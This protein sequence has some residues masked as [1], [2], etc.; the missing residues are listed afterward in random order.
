MPD[1]GVGDD[2]PADRQTYRGRRRVSRSPVLW[3]TEERLRELFGDGI[4]ELRVERRASRQPFRSPDHYLDFFRTYFGPLQR[5]ST[6]S[7]LRA[8]RR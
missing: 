8:S 3:G 7:V 6:R 1:G 5:P 2:V 4:A